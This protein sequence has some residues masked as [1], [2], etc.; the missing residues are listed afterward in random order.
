MVRRD[1][2][3]RR[4]VWRAEIV[5]CGC[6]FESGGGWVGGL[7]CVVVGRATHGYGV[8]VCR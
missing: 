5:G 7:V 4:A 2:V 8:S 3:W 6:S 1:W